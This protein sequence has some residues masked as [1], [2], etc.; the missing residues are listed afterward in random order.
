MLGALPRTASIRESCR[1]RTSPI[2]SS[3]DKS[4]GGGGVSIV[5]P[6][7][8]NRSRS[9]GSVRFGSPFRSWGGE[10]GNSRGFFGSITGLREDKMRGP[11]LFTPA[12]PAMGNFASPVGSTLVL[13]AAEKWACL[14]RYCN[15]ATF[16]SRHSATGDSRQRPL[17]AKNGLFNIALRAGWFARS[18]IFFGRFGRDL[19]QTRRRC[20]IDS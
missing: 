16:H 5:P 20:A 12:E 14:I 19:L 15:N 2:E 13:D 6:S 18:A 11:E 1:R 10:T 4:P 17:C 3:R 8:T 7:P 9:S